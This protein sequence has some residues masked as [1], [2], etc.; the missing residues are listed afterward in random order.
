MLD[1]STSRPTSKLA[2]RKKDALS[3]SYSQIPMNDGYDSLPLW[4][5]SAAEKL[6]ANVSKNMLSKKDL[7]DI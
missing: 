4:I 7:M 3:L 1:V 6:K 2:Q 5:A